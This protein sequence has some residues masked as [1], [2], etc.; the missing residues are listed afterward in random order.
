V[1]FKMKLGRYS[2]LVAC[3]SLLVV[4]AAILL[5]ALKSNR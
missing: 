1:R 3:A 2:D 5:F 4:V